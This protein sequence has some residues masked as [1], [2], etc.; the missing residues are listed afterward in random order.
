MK[1]FF[2][3]L[4]LLSTIGLVGK[5]TTPVYWASSLMETEHSTR[6]SILL[7]C[8]WCGNGHPTIENIFYDGLN[9]YYHLSCPCGHQW[10]IQ[11]T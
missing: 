6:A 1:Q 3:A 5:P 11:I 4:T 7:Y 2:A 10:A 8:D 9:L